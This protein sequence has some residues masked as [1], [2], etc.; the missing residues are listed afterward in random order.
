MRPRFS[1]SRNVE[2]HI[3]SSSKSKHPTQNVKPLIAQETD[4]NWILLISRGIWINE[5]WWGNIAKSERPSSIR[6]RRSTQAAINIVDKTEH[7]TFQVCRI[8][9]DAINRMKKKKKSITREASFA[10]N[11]I[12]T[13]LKTRLATTVDRSIAV[14]NSKNWFQFVLLSRN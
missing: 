8:R 7:S 9:W 12:I 2:S 3:L 10:I 14:H 1:F 5:Y 11:A 4:A 6:K 13:T